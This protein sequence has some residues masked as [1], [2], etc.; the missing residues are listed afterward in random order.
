MSRG[1]TETKS[2]TLTKQGGCKDGNAAV[3][4]VEMIKWKVCSAVMRTKIL[5]SNCGSAATFATS[6]L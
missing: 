6:R 4:K 3:L 2:S 1:K 5:G